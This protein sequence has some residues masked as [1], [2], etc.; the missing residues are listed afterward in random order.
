MNVSPAELPLVSIVTPSLNQGEFIEAAIRSVAEQDYPQIEHIV[1]DGGSTDATLD[2]L[3][4][5]PEVRWLSEPDDGQAAAI[6]KGFRLARGEIF[7]WLNADDLYL[8]GA[9]SAA[10]AAL[11]EHDAALVFGSW[12]QVD[13]RGETLRRV[14]VVPFDYRRQLEV[15]NAVAQPTA[16]F[17]RAAYEAVGGVDDSYRYAMDYELWLKLG[18]YK[19]VA[20]ERELAAF[21]YH[22]DSKTVAEPE[23]FWPETWR[24]ARSHGARLRSPLFLDYYL[25]RRHPRLHVLVR[26][27]RRVVAPF[28]GR[29]Q[30]A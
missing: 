9:V 28:R 30:W 25:P 29:R 24:A 15:V 6:N 26:G 10:V 27:A 4:R 13:E 19:V 3:H 1:V 7:A 21:R 12:Q 18:R 5:H 20:I 22:G 11:R 14:R 23:G 16:F 2:V 17:T 8:P